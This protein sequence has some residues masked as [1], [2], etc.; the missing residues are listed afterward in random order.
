VG[1]AG[2]G[3][4]AF[5]LSANV[6]ARTSPDKMQAG[7]NEIRGFILEAKLSL[8]MYFLTMKIRPNEKFVIKK[9]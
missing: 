1:T 5:P 3:S 9:I 8:L 2:A 4:C 6:R 7:K